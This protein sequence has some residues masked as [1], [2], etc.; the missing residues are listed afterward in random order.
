MN[1]EIQYTCPICKE[2]HET[3]AYRLVDITGDPGLEKKLADDSLFTCEC[4]T[5]GCGIH[6]NYSFLYQDPDIRQYIYVSEEPPASDGAALD[7]LEHNAFAL[8]E[9]KTKDAILRIVYSRR[10]LKEKLE[11]FAHGMD[12]RILEICKG[13]ALSQFPA[14][15]DFFVTDI[16]YRDI[17]GQEVLSMQ[18][19]D[20]TEQYVLDFNGMYQQMQQAYAH[21]LPPLRGDAFC[22]VDLEYA[23]AFLRGL[24]EQVY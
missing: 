13:I 8:A 24:E 6:L 15:E 12:D 16:R 9:G 14:T 22:C 4:P 20:G 10:D 11:V 3:K 18:I 1:D 17:G 19:S 2:T 23:A 5:C 21:L 7:Q